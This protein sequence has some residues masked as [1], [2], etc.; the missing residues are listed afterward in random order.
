MKGLALFGRAPIVPALPSPVGRADSTEIAV[1]TPMGNHAP[2]EPNKLPPSST[3]VVPVAPD[4]PPNEPRWRA[5]MPS[6]G[7]L[8]PVPSSEVGAPARP[9]DLREEETPESFFHLFA[10]LERVAAG[11]SVLGVTSA[12]SGEGVTTVALHLALSIA[13]STYRRV[14][15]VDL[16]LGEDEL[17]R[18]VGAAPAPCGLMDYL[19]ADRPIIAL[20]WAGPEYFTLFPAGRK[21]ISAARTARTP[22]IASLIAALRAEFDIVIVDLP[23]VGSDN[24][25]PIAQQLD[26]VVMVARAGVTPRALIRQAVTT[27]GRDSVTGV[28]LNRVT[29]GRRRKQP[30]RGA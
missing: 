24:C 17:C 25:L 1:E 23:S 3:F 7:R 6:E 26:S 18:R 13:Q 8:L 4:G 10:T 29:T 30:Q 2:T 5:L 12:I 27:L 20:D 21:P 11:Q 9:L 16:S 14:C 19:E 28:V 22:R 15:L